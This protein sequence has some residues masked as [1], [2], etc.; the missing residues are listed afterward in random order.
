MTNINQQTL[1]WLTDNVE[2]ITNHPYG[3][4]LGAIAL[5]IGAFRAYIHMKSYASS[6]DEFIA[7]AKE[8]HASFI[9]MDARVEH[10]MFGI[11]DGIIML[12]TNAPQLRYLHHET[13]ETGFTPYD[14]RREG[15]DFESYAETASRI[16]QMDVEKL[17][18]SLKNNG[19]QVV[20][21]YRDCFTEMYG[22]KT[23]IEI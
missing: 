14:S 17:G 18:R 4:A 21:D 1:E 7:R 16:F 9:T 2:P 10:G 3:I 12:R 5:G 15:H 19:F 22:R 6:L 23:K 8:N 11:F 20:C 13:I